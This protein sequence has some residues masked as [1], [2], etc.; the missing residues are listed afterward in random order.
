MTQAPLS[1]EAYTLQLDNSGSSSLVVWKHGREL[2]ELRQ[3]CEEKEQEKRK[4]MLLLKNRA[5]LSF[6]CSRKFR[7]R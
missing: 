4:L 3:E 6:S 1:K 5:F 2:E 7:I